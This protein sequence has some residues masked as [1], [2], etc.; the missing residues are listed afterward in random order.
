MIYLDY[1]STYP[2]YESII[3]QIPDILKEYNFNPSARYKPA[4]KSKDFLYSMR[5]KIAE[6]LNAVPEQIIFTSTATEALNTIIKGVNIKHKNKVIVSNLEHKALLEPVKNLKSADIHIMEI[7]KGYV[8][9][10]DL[11]DVI[12]EKTRIV[13]LMHVNNESGALC[14]V[15]EISEK[16]KKNYPDI[17]ILSDMVQSFGKI[18]TD[19]K[20]IDFAVMSSHKIGGLKGAGILYAKH[21]EIIKPLIIG[22]GQEFNLRSGTE[23][24][25]SIWSMYEALSITKKNF[26]EKLSHLEMLN[27]KLIEFCKKNNFTINSPEKSVPWIFNFSTLNVFSEIMINHLSSKNIYVSSA[28]AC[29][30]KS[31]SHVLQ[32]MKFGKKITDTAIRVS[33]SFNT[34]EKEIDIFCNEIIKAVDL[35][36]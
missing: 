33:M 36:S 1:A 14:D 34:M 25:L 2:V 20:N 12:D 28:S 3:K 30:G 5:K 11:L 4:L 9:F 17:L 6:Y 18:K 16:I 13:S 35:L 24:I 31:K 21:P 32:N 27:K 23:N 19:I 8:D 15:S 26:K 29:S 10:D 22:G 7:P